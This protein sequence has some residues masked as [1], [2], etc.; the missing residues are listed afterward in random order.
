MWVRK[1]ISFFNFCLV[2]SKILLTFANGLQM[3]VPSIRYEHPYLLS[4]W[5]GLFYWPTASE[6]E[7]VTSWVTG[8]VNL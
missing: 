5:L 8:S 1:N 6:Y 4:L 3:I 2:V 7:L